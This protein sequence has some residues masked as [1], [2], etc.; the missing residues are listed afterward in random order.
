MFLSYVVCGD[1]AVARPVLCIVPDKPDQFSNLIPMSA[2]CE[3]D[4]AYMRVSGL[5]ALLVRVDQEDQC[6]VL[7]PVAPSKLYITPDLHDKPGVSVRA[8]KVVP[9][10]ENRYQV[11]FIQEIDSSGN[12]KE[13]S[14]VKLKTSSQKV[15]R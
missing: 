12:W 10:A 5:E 2:L 13:W 6:F 9:L 4:S 7:E 8:L 14:P 11:F 15:A 1:V 3:S